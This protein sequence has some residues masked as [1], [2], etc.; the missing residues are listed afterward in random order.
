MGAKRLR[1][2]SH[3]GTV[4]PGRRKKIENAGL[5]SAAGLVESEFGAN[6]D[7]SSQASLASGLPSRVGVLDLNGYTKGHKDHPKRNVPWPVPE[8]LIQTYL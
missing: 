2:K 8:S 3:F 1:D 6:P 5:L 7:W 4:W